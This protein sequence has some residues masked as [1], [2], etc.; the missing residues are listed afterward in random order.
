MNPTHSVTQWI[1]RL[2]EGDVAAAEVL[3]RRYFDALVRVARSRYSAASRGEADPEDY[4]LSAFADICQKAAAGRYPLLTGR[5]GL[6]GL[7][8]DVTAKKAL[9]QRRRETTAKRGGSMIAASLQSEATLAGVPALL[10]C[11]PDPSEIAAMAEQVR[12]LLDCLRDERL[13]AVALWKLQGF[14][15]DE[16]ADKVGCVTRTV[17]RKLESIRQSW[18]RELLS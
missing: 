15:N 3:W 14:T 12:L 5:D 18:T 4:A 16:I 10:Q 8:L 2:K 11:D 1:S 7:M 13:R 17:E 9:R 6:W